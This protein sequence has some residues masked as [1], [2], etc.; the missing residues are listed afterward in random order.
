MP[1]MTASDSTVTIAGM[2]FSAPALDMRNMSASTF[3]AESLLG[4]VF[5]TDRVA[6]TN[7]SMKSK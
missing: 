5:K 2:F 4:L 3:E 6:R 7:S 1:P